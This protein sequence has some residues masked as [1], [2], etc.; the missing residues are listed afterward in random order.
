MSFADA[1]NHKT[2]TQ[3]YNSAS[4]LGTCKLECEW[5]FEMLGKY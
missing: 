5:G 3:K 4:K 2:H 1:I